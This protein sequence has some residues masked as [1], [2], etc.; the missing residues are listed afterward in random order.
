MSQA[1]SEGLDLTQFHEVFFDEAAEHLAEMESLLLN[2]DLSAPDGEEVNA[3]FRAAHSI[4][5]GAA[6]F[7]FRDITELTHE[8]ETVF[9]KVRRNEMPLSTDLIDVFLASGD[10]L[11][12]LLNARRAGGTGAPSDETADLCRRLKAFLVAGVATAVPATATIASGAPVVAPGKQVL[13]LV[14]GPIDAKLSVRDID[15]A[16]GDLKDFGTCEE[17]KAARDAERRYRIV[18]DVSAEDLRDALAFMVDPDKVRVEVVI[19]TPAASITDSNWQAAP[20]EAARPMDEGDFG[21]F[22]H[23]E[24]AAVDSAAA[25]DAIVPAAPAV[26]T[27]SNKPAVGKAQPGKQ[28][29]ASGE[30]SSIRVSIDK[31]D[32][33][34]NLVGEL[35]ITQAMLAQSASKADPVLFEALHAGLAQLER[36]TRG[37][38]EAAM[39]IRMM[40]MSSVFSRFPRVVRDLAAKLGKE[41]EL[42]TVGEATELDKGLIERIVDPMTHLVRNSLDHGLEHR[43]RGIGRRQGTRPR[44]DS[45]Q[46]ARTRPGHLR[47]HA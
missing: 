42:K 40:P 27:E 25:A 7:G 1:E 39:S 32:Q 21:L 29:A 44:Q 33:L 14:F 35:V 38:Q 46:G 13:E 30:S 4:K 11:N 5:G 37:L 9:D 41:V 43:H 23:D 26:N 18:T 19:D 24:M 22:P 47:R 16:I 10:K 34:I 3:I 17:L 8:M 6:T 45:R 20:T 28:S 31:V 12:A 2:I 36:N 15:S